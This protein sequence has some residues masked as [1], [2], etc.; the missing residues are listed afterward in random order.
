MLPRV[1]LGRIRLLD[2]GYESLE[3]V[4]GTLIMINVMPGTPPW[5]IHS[6]LFRGFSSNL[7]C[8]MDSSHH[9]V[10]QPQYGVIASWLS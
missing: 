5:S 8:A 7:R 10:Q 4:V 3:N 9:A 2:L 1:A 6:V